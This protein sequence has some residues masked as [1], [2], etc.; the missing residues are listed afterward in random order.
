MDTNNYQSFPERDDVIEVNVDWSPFIYFIVVGGF[1]IFAFIVV[2]IILCMR[3]GNRRGR[4][5]GSAVTANP[6]VFVT[7]APQ[8]SVA[9]A[10][11]PPYNP[12]FQQPQ[13]YQANIQHSYANPQ[14]IGWQDPK[15]QP[16]PPTQ[17]SR[18]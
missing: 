7:S 12:N 16:T 9:H 15:A 6:T 8:H 13:Q 2:A 10:Q 3:R 17:M 5:Y 4:V 11:P 14:Q 1:T 18:W